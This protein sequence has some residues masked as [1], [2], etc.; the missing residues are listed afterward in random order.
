MRLT[1]GRIGGRSEMIKI[2]GGWDVLNYWKLGDFQWV[3]QQL[4]DKLK[5]GHMI[6]P[7]KDNIFRSLQMVPFDNVRVVIMGQ[8]PFPDPKYPTGMAFDVD[9]SVPLHNL[10][11]TL[12][13][14]FNEYVDDLHYPYPKTGSLIEWCY[15]GVLLLNA[16][17]TCDAWKSKSHD[18]PAWHLMTQEIVEKLSARGQTV[19]VFLGGVARRFTR[20][21]E[22]GEDVLEYSHPSPRASDSAHHPFLGSRMF[23]TVNARLVAQGQQ[24]INWRLS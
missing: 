5:A 17:P 6:C 9:A 12:K 11:P 21:V 14:I 20:Y 18:W 8:D 10:P 16:L 19:F 22:P 4:N 15:E 2:R 1:K 23:S 7:G 13:T 3:L 24:P